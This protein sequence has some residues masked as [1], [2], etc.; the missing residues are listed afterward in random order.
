MYLEECCEPYSEGE[1]EDDDGQAYVVRWLLF[2][3]KANDET[4]HQQFF[5]FILD[6][7]SYENIIAREITIKLGLNIE[8]HPEFYTIGWIK[9]VPKIAVI[10]RC[11]IPFFHKQLYK[12]EVYCDV[13]DMN[14]C[15]LFGRPW[16][17]NVNAW[18]GGQEN[19]YRFVKDGINFTLIPLKRNSQ[20]KAQKAR[21][22]ALKQMSW[23]GSWGH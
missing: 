11:K 18:H 10:E 6:S 9:K 4:T 20:P 13:F 7:S 3:P 21:G 22:K 17:Y 16:Q 1:Y 23:Q 19:I 5:Y 12:D 2:T 14:A 8:K 15:N